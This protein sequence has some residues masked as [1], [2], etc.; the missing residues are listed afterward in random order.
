MVSNYSKVFSLKSTKG[1]NTTVQNRLYHEKYYKLFKKKFSCK[2]CQEG[3]GIHKKTLGTNI[4]SFLI[5]MQL[6]RVT[7]NS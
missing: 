2:T 5:G 3:G 1:I 6:G 7:S 4:S